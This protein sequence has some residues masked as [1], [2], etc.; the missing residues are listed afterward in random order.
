MKGIICEVT[1]FRIFKNICWK[2]ILS[3]LNYICGL[4]KKRWLSYLKIM[5]DR[6][7]LWNQLGLEFSWKELWE[8]FLFFFKYGTIFTFS[9]QFG[10]LFLSRNLLFQHYHKFSIKLFII[11]FIIIL[12]SVIFV[13]FLFFK[14]LNFPFFMIS[15][16]RNLSKIDVWLS[17]F[18]LLVFF[19]IDIFSYSLVYFS[20]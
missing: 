20:C 8:I 12:K 10:N 13:Q 18:S 6:F 15:L 17:C 7:N 4:V 2:R 9:S 11:S 1:K 14:F 19:F 5:F 3:S 16:A